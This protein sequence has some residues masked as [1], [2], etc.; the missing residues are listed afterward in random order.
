M[1]KIAIRTQDI[2][3]AWEAFDG[4]DVSTFF[5]EWDGYLAGDD[6]PCGESA[7]G[8]HQ[9]SDGSCDLCGS[10]NGESS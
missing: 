1:T 4:D 6:E 5:L 10:K 8:L 7:D 3:E 9:V 2:I